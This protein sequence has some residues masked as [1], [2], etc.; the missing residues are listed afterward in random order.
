MCEG[1]STR[2][3]VS[4]LERSSVVYVRMYSSTSS[5]R[6]TSPSAKLVRASRATAT[7][8]RYS[9]T[10]GMPSAAGARERPTSPATAIRVRTYGSAS[11]SVPSV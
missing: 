7:G 11:N 1:S 6:R 5:L 8:L 10:Y 3:A 4:P 9:L 2:S